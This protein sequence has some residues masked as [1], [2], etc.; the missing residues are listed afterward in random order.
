MS[1]HFKNQLVM[2]KRTKRKTSTRRNLVDKTNILTLEKNIPLPSNRGSRSESRV[3][4]EKVDTLVS[5]MKVGNS[6]VIPGP[7]LS[8]VRKHINQTYSE[9]AFRCSYTSKD[10]NF[11]RVWRTQ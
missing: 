10:K 1:Y 11:V 5:Q 7:K 3:I 9:K 2:N 8:I 6:F 4:L